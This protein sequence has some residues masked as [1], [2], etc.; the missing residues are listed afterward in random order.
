MSFSSLFF[1]LI[2]GYYYIGGLVSTMSQ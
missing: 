1:L 2:S